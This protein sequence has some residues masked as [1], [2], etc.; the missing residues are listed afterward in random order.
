MSGRLAGKVAVI[1]GAA[2]G[3]GRSMARAM[4][5][6]GA[7]VVAV[8]VDADRLAAVAAELGCEHAVVDITD[9]AA[10][11]QLLDRERVD[12]LCN[13]AGILDALTPLADV[14]D[15]LWDRVMRINLDGPFYA[16]RAVL[17]KM[18]EAGGGVIL[19]TCSAAALSGG[20]AGAAYT[21][22]KH[23]LL[24]ITR[25]IAWYYGDKGIRCN[26]IAPGAIQT[27]M[28]VREAPHTGGFERYGAYFPTMPPHGRA[29]DVAR[30]AAFLVS[31]DA[32]YV[33]GEI[34][35][36]DGGWNAF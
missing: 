30:V 20:R 27:K 28:H 36:V 9:D 16:C 23:A 25:S 24:G 17:P 10:V 7:H 12:I 15:A 5:D 4:V 3:I 34:V 26:A 29:A 14:T 11:R 32:V 8:D 1:T 2:S 33:N 13:N 31:D 6:D 22:S 35:S 21:A 19:N 18:V